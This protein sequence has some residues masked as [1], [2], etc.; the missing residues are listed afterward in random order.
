[1]FT[2]DAFI[3]V[4]LTWTKDD[5]G[6]SVIINMNQRWHSYKGQGWQFCKNYFNRRCSTLAF[7]TSV[8]INFIQR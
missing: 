1:M 7:L 4:L 3:S 5:I 6:Q 8:I 2:D